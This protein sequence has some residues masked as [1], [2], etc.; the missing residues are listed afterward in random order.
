MQFITTTELRTQS[1]KLVKTL[2]EGNSVYLIHRS[3]VIAIIIPKNDPQPFDSDKVR[4][5]IKKT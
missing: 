5:I 3:K 1:K 2:Q 4:K